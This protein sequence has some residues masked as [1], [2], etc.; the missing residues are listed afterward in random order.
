MIVG[1]GRVVLALRGEGL[2][3]LVQH[4]HEVVVFDQFAFAFARVLAGGSCGGGAGAE[5]GLAR[6]LA[7]RRVGAGA[8]I[9]GVVD[10]LIV[11]LLLLVVVLGV[12]R[13]AEHGLPAAAARTCGSAA[14]APAVGHDQLGLGGGEE[15]AVELHEL[16]LIEAGA[17]DVLPRPRERAEEAVSFLLTR[18]RINM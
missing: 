6:R 2:A 9:V 3:E 14:P 10:V 1:L 16:R 8:H 7:A 13:L 12:G 15:V 4:E 18:G 11:L 17:E 5:R